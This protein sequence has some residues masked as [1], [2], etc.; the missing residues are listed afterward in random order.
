MIWIGVLV[1]RCKCFS[2]PRHW[3]HLFLGPLLIIFKR[4]ECN[5]LDSQ[6]CVWETIVK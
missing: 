6:Y 1:E 4:A 2:L 3:S 5:K